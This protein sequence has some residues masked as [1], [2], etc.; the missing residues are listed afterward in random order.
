MSTESAWTGWHR[1]PGKG[2][3]WEPVTSG[4]TWSETWDKLLRYPIT[5]DRVV[6]RSGMAPEMNH[7]MARRNRR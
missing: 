1:R 2:P 4:S 3:R 6:L 7:N 5:G